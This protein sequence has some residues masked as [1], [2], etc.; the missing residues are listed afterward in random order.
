MGVE[1]TVLSKSMVVPTPRP[2]ES[3]ELLRL[4]LTGFDLRLIKF[5]PF[6]VLLLFDASAQENL[7]ANQFNERLRES[8][9][10]A[11]ADYYPFAG[12]LPTLQ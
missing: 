9:S 2:D 11:L 4:Q 12:K 10:R 1:V 5:P 8:L 3:R 7:I 6:R